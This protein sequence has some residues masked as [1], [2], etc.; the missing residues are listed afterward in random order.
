MVTT[1]LA[2]IAV[3]LALVSSVHN[4]YKDK[5]AETQTSQ[6]SPN[7]NDSANSFIKTIP[8]TEKKEVNRKLAETL[9]A[10]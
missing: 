9:C 7:P 10:A 8:L 1:F 5:Q 4:A 6:L 2:P 3:S